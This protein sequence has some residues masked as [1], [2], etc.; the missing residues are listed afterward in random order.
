M[1]AALAAVPWIYVKQRFSLRTLL[2]AMMLVA[3]VL[4]LVVALK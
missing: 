4:G 3:A 1:A 2:I